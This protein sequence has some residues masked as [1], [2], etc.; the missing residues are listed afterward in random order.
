MN[1]IRFTFNASLNN[2]ND[3]REV[4]LVATAVGVGRTH[5]LATG[6]IITWTADFLREKAASFIGMPV[7][8]DLDEED[9]PTGHSR[10]AVGAIKAAYFDEGEQGVIVT[11]ALWRH[12]AP[13][14]VERIKELANDPDARDRIQ[15]SME[16]L[17]EG[18]LIA[19]GDGSESPADGEFSGLGIV[20]IGAD[21]RNRLILVA[22]L[23][24][25][26]AKETMDDSII[27]KIV[28]KVGARFSL[29]QPNTP[30]QDRDER[31]AELTAAHEGSLEWTGRRLAEH[32]AAKRGDDYDAPY[33]YVVATYPKYAIY[34]EGESY[35]QINYTRKGRDMTF[36]EPV[37]VDPTYNPVEASASTD[38]DADLSQDEEPTLATEISEEQKASLRSEL[39]TELKPQLDELEAVKAENVTLKAEKAAADEA[40]AKKELVAARVAE[41]E[42]IRPA[43][44][45][46]KQRRE[47]LCAALDDTAFAAYKAEMAAAV[48]VKGGLATDATRH[49][50]TEDEG[51]SLTEEQIASMAGR[52]LAASGH[53]A[54]AKDK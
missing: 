24:E 48:E 14:T 49:E 3:S 4:T 11:A 44:D 46:G 5:R 13:H 38:M 37:E 26:E 40:A 18:E 29:K 34:Q 9:E 12:Y 28:A 43:D 25:D 19:N 52:A 42:T 7:N 53:A 20:R 54:P 21:P 17:P 39:L 15:V 10:R 32:L 2:P 27:D 35:F 41:L 22:A 16:F 50:G 45:D 6:Q 51:N 47:A 36:D 33:S 31:N 23:A 30:E 1:P 8:I